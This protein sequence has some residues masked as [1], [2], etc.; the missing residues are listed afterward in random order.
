L[1][2]EFFGYADGVQILEPQHLAEFMKQKLEKAATAYNADIWVD[3]I[4]S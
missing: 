3:E 2:R 1:Q 4:K